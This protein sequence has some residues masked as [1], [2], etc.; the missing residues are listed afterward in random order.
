MMSYRIT[1]TAVI[2]SLLMSVSVWAEKRLDNSDAKTT[3]GTTDQTAIAVPAANV[4]QSEESTN[5]AGGPLGLTPEIV[6]IPE[7]P[8]EAAAYAVPW[9]S[10]NGGGGNASTATHK[11]SVSIGQT[12]IGFAATAAHQAGIGYWYGITAGG[13]DC[14]AQG[15]MNCD[16]IVQPIDV[17]FLVNWV[18]RDRNDICNAPNCPYPTGDLDCSGLIQPIDVV[19]IIN[20]VYRDRNDV[21]DGCAPMP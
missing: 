14:G 6:P 11:V 19:L 13:C 10:I 4:P 15:D 9:K 21:C 2:L 16:G 12:T 20:L 5:A 17:T 3:T 18:Y 8:D 7:I 1:S